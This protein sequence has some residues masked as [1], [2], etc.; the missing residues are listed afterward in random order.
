M[1]ECFSLTGK[2]W[3]LPNELAVPAQD[4]AKF[5]MKK[6]LLHTPPI[7]GHYPD[8]NRA[9]QR[10]R[11]AVLSKEH[12]GIFGDYDCDGITAT[13]QLLRYFRRH[14]LEPVTRLPHRVHDG[15]GL[16]EENIQWFAKKGVSL[17]ITV[18]T[19]ITGIPAV[20]AANA[21]GIDVLITDHHKPQAEIPSA[22]AILHPMLSPNCPEPH[23]SGAGVVLALLEEL[24]DG[25]WDEQDVDTALA[26]IG[27]VADVVPLL[28]ANRTLV[29][30]GLLSL[31]TIRDCPL[32]DLRDSTRASTSTDVA[33]R[34]APRINAAGRMS[35]PSV[36]LSAIVEGG[37]ALVMLDE[38]NEQRQAQMVFLYEEALQ[39]IAEP[40]SESLLWV[41]G[42]QYPHGIIG[43][44][45]G[46]LTER[47]GKPS[48]AVTIDGDTCTA[49]LRSPDKYHVT[50]GLTRCKHL[51]SAYGGHAQAAGCSFPLSHIDDVQDALTKDV[52]S[53][54][55][56][57]L[58]RPCIT[59]DAKL[60]PKEITV[61]LLEELQTL[62]PYGQKNP[63]PRFI[64]QNV[65]MEDMRLVGAD[66]SHLQCKIGNCKAIGFGL[67]SLHTDCNEKMD[68][69]C[70]IGIDEWNGRRQPQIF[71]E[72][73]RLS[74]QVRD[75]LPSG[76]LV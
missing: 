46:K 14:S 26:M 71:I 12:I 10:I 31:A 7:H 27:T 13:A 51:L 41:A 32:A 58:L 69:L 70:R 57:K 53:H 72:D 37:E 52:E 15:Y 24:E 6:R 11:K 49:S 25:Q 5:L 30:K 59:V 76:T 43:L 75:S 18:D 40:S 68:V 2:Q 60:T 16:Q 62:E 50:D 20:A 36:A 29:Q 47:Y 28:G 48:C 1:A 67:G 73:V 42:A 64:L 39:S 45:A 4:I 55:D 38:L 74:R 65:S 66:E 44:L 54:V 19:G 21:L 23:P 3:I 17:I 8:M 61:S 63:E 35:D 34:I 56:V 9:V 22:Y 33:F